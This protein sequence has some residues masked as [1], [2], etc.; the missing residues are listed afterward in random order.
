MGQIHINSEH[1]RN[2]NKQKQKQ[3]TEEIFTSIGEDRFE[4]IKQTYKIINVDY[5]DYNTVQW[6]A[7]DEDSNTNQVLKNMTDF[8]LNHKDTPI[9]KKTDLLCNTKE[10]ICIC[11]TH[12]DDFRRIYDGN[13]YKKGERYISWCR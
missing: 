4:N 8:Y 9:Y 12:A 6:Q 7:F 5:L 10:N 3:Y 1:E 2:S 11:N 13:N